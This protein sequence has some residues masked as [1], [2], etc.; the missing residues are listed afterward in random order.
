[1]KS[2][3]TIV[4]LLM[5][6]AS[7]DAQY[8]YPSQIIIASPV[9]VLPPP[10]TPNFVADATFYGSYYGYAPNGPRLAPVDCY[11]CY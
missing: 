3:S 7:A 4:V 10:I 2:L 6:T 1:M 8:F 11:G 9:I 5:L